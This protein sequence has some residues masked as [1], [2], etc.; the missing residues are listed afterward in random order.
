M[1]ILLWIVFGAIAG[2]IASMFMK[3]DSSQGLVMDIIMGII[4]AVVG[5]YIMEFFGKS[6]V[7]GFNFYSMAVAVAGACVVIFIGRK[8]NIGR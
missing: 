3:S 8:L 4:G 2:W 6:V 1:G 5:G 7:T